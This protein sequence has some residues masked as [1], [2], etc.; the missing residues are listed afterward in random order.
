MGLSAGARMAMHRGEDPMGS[1]KN[2][3]E[4]ALAPHLKQMIEGL[5]HLAAEHIELVRAEVSQ[6]TQAFRSQL[7]RLILFAF[8]AATGY[9][10]LGAALIVALTTWMTIGLA[11]LCVG[12]AHL[13]CGTLGVYYAVKRLRAPQV[14]PA[15]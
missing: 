15:L 7:G 12:V 11:L 9:V 14:L 2:P 6:N 13:I 8:L 10:F 1:P 4:H 5:G 3:S